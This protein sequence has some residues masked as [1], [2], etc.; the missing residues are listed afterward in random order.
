MREHWIDNGR[1][2]LSI[3]TDTMHISIQSHARKNYHINSS[4]WHLYF[5]VK[6]QYGY[7]ARFCCTFGGTMEEALNRA[8]TII[9]EM[10]ESIQEIL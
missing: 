10:F 5:W 1:G 2:L 3:D 8:E 6:G 4:I 9:R 7:M